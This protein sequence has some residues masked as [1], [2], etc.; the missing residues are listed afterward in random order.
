MP[1]PLSGSDKATYEAIFRHPVAHNLEW[2]SLI[3]VFHHLGELEE[4]AN[5]KLKF[6]RNRQTL[7]LHR[8]GKDVEV[9]DIMHIRHFLDSSNAA[10]ERTTPA[11]KD[12][13]V[14]L[15]HS[16]ARIF[17]AG[18]EGSEPEHVVPLDPLGH[19]Q[20]VHNPNGDSGGKQGPLRKTFY[21]ALAKKLEES[22]RI[23]L[24]GDGKGASSEV[25]HFVAELQHHHHDGLAKRVVG[26]EVANISHM[27]AG[28]YRAKAHGFFSGSQP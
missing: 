14:I 12:V 3:S 23:L 25:D 17:H 13:V 18:S 24:I 27:T 8:R 2:R 11:S 22:D 6:S 7:T 19:D 5:G 26:T 9:E 4:E 16:G 20:Q 28:D 15:D 1:S 10:T 21:E